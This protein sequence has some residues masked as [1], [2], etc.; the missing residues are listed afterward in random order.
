[1]KIFQP[2]YD[3]A[4]VWA[5][6]KRAPWL[7]ALLSF[8]EAIFFPVPPEFM[9]LP[10]C[11]AKPKSGFWYAAISLSGSVLG[12]FIGY[13]IGY[14]AMD[15]VLPLLDKL[16]YGEQFA[17]VRET[18]ANGSHAQAF[19]L[20]VL[21]GFTPVPFKIFTIASGAVGMPLIPFFF[22]AVIGRGKR[23]FL[24]ALAIRL[25][26][27]KAEATLRKYIEPIGWIALVLLFGAIGWL[28]WRGHAG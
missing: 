10:M 28:W 23:V 21:A 1:M 22:G 8:C 24:V 12:M 25:G 9:L 26:G 27:E 2:M 5:S 19:W 6:H 16:G 18:V 11:I 13:A 3:R 17:Q 20:L 14:Y 4:L 15:A 7:L